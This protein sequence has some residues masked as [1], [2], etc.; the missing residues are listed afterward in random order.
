MIALFGFQCSDDV[1][2]IN[3]IVNFCKGVL[4]IVKLMTAIRKADE[5]RERGEQ[6]RSLL[7]RSR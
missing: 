7:G 2:I 6:S 5:R 1:S 4:T 3:G